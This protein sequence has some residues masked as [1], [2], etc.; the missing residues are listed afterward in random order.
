M[1][2]RLEEKISKWD[3]SSYYLLFRFRGEIC[4]IFY[5]EKKINPESW[6]KKSSSKKLFMQ[7]CCCCSHIV[8]NKRER[9]L[10]RRNKESI[11]QILSVIQLWRK[12]CFTLTL[13]KTYRDSGCDGWREGEKVTSNEQH[14]DEQQT[15]VSYKLL[16]VSLYVYHCNDIIWTIR[17]DTLFLCWKLELVR[18]KEIQWI[19]IVCK[20]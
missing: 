18:L 11:I 16:L 14:S 12:M 7:N 13:F 9:K 5:P 6:T 20:Q 1:C 19:N 2:L 15:V 4:I 17:D 8:A 3:V 10:Y